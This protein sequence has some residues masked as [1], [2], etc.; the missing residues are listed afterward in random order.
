[1]IKASENRVR[2]TWRDRLPVL[3]LALLATLACGLF[4]MTHSTALG[5]KAVPRAH[6]ARTLQASDTAHMHYISAKGAA[7]IEEGK[8]AGTLPGSMRVNFV[9]GATFS[10]S[11]TISTHGGSITGHG[12]ATPH[13]AGL[14]E[15]FAGSL[16]VTSGT[17]RYKH[18][19]GRAGLSGTFNRNSYAL[20][21]QTT[22]KLSF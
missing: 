16:T 14:N 7:L 9:V 1:M 6:T 17:G 21:V 12:S 4:G 2:T 5:A 11:F 15:S 13:G 22:G 20:T 10:G 19:H 18:A 8:A 3:G